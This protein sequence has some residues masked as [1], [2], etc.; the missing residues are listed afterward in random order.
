MLQE[1][2]LIIQN[3]WNK[4]SSDTSKIAKIF[5]QNLFEKNPEFKKLF[6]E[7][8]LRQE[9][10]F[11]N[12]M[13]F[14]IRNLDR[15]DEGFFEIEKLGKRHKGFRVKPKYYPVFREAFIEIFSNYKEAN[16]NSV[17]IDAFKRFF[18]VISEK[19]IEGASKDPGYFRGKK[20]K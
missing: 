8:E 13:T 14:I 10:K 9:V 2:H 18:D 19:M 20:N 3:L 7:D 12:T 6:K 11:I 17:E 15:L 1:D 16:I 4:I 5:Y